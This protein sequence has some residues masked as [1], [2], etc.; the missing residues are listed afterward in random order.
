MGAA[1][2]SNLLRHRIPVNLFDT[3]GPKNVP[4]EVN[5][6]VTS[7]LEMVMEMESDSLSHSLPH[8]KG[9][10]WYDSAAAASAAS[11]VVSR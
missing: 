9:A 6:E 11:D 4:S 5:I 2:A 8:I 10:Q 3:A 7:S 1:V